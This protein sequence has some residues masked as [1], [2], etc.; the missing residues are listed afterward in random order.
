MQLAE[1]CLKVN[2]KYY[3][4]IKSAT[5]IYYNPKNLDKLKEMIDFLIKKQI[6]IIC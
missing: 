1:K 2:D 4:K 5:E 3:T 6:E